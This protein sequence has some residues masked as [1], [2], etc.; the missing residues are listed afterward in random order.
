VANENFKCYA[1]PMPPSTITVK[2]DDFSLSN[3]YSFPSD[4][5][6]KV[7]EGQKDDLEYDVVLEW[8]DED[9]NSEYYLDVESRSDFLVS[10]LTFS[11]LYEDTHRELKILGRSQRVYTGPVG[12]QYV[13]RLKLL[14]KEGDLAD[15][16]DIKGAILRLKLPGPGVHL[17]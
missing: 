15:D 12:G 1:R 10:Q 11:L 6:E 16:I 4:F 13:Q 5:I 14:D 8:P 17:T 2:G 3:E 9:P 7:K